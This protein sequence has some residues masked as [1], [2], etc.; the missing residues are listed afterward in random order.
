MIKAALDT[1]IVAALIDEKDKW[2]QRAYALRERLKAVNAEIVLFDPVINEA[3]SV[4]VRRLHEQ[5]RSQQVARI[6]KAVEVVVPVDQ[7]TWVSP[8]TP[9]LYPQIISLVQEHQGHLNFHDALI[10]LVS[11]ELAVTHIVSFDSDFDRISW[12][13]R[14][15]DPAHIPSR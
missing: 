10:A 8:E 13:I 4:L 12:L 9:R 1:V 2:H 11:R 15:S 6:L 7:I 14:I 3:V 5:G